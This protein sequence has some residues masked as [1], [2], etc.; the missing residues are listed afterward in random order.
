MAKRF[1]ERFIDNQNI[2]KETAACGGSNGLKKKYIQIGQQ[3]QYNK[4]SKFRNL[5][6]MVCGGLLAD[7]LSHR[8]SDLKNKRKEKQSKKQS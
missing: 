4:D 6:L 8:F 2:L 5:I 1:S 7:S 3:L